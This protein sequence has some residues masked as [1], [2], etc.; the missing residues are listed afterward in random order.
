MDGTITELQRDRGVG[1]VLGADGKTYL[2]RR[3]ALQDAWF[4]ELREG[5]AVTFEPTKDASGLRA[6]FIRI[7]RALTNQQRAAHRHAGHE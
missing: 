1:N 3:G 2:F 5:V 6:K 7:V 4:H